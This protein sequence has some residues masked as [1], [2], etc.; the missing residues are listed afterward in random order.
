M[1]PE[2]AEAVRTV[3]WIAAGAF[4]ATAVILAAIGTHAMWMMGVWQR[5]ILGDLA[6]PPYI[7]PPPPPVTPEIDDA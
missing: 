6:P 2:D 3:F 7:V 4:M 1:T 5:R